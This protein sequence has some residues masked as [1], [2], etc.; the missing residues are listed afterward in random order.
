MRHV[1]VIVAAFSLAVLGGCATQSGGLYGLEV[2]SQEVVFVMDVSPSMAG[3]QEQLLWKRQTTGVIDEVARSG[4]RS[5]NSVASG[6]GT[7]LY[8]TVNAEAKE[9][10]TKLAGAKRELTASIE[11]LPPSTH[12][13][14]VTFSKNVT[15]WNP[16]LQPATAQ[17]KA[18]AESFVNAALT[19]SDTYIGAALKAA[20]AIDGVDEIFLITD[21]EPTD[22][23][24]NDILA[25]VAQ[26]NA[27]RGVRIN[28]VG[29]GTD[30]DEAFLRTLAAHNRGVYVQRMN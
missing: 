15:H 18:S 4:A 12:F 9:R 24:P 20:L 30:Q 29:L 1:R 5:I 28:A 2:S 8:K 16:V 19:S 22:K 7:A 23:T 3:E 10:L 14:V 27:A 13:T 11:Q 21:G 25:S 26:I 17:N 6:L